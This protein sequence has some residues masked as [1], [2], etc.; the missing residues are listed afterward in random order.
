[1]WCA[2]VL[3]T[4]RPS[5]HPAPRAPPG[6]HAPHQATSTRLHA[7][8]IPTHHTTPMPPLSSTFFLPASSSNGQTRSG[9]RRSG[10]SSQ[11][12]AIRGGTAPPAGPRQP[13]PPRPALRG[14]LPR[15]RRRPPR[16]PP[17]RL[18]PPRPPLLRRPAPRPRRRAHR[19]LLRRSRTELCPWQADRGLPRL[20]R[21]GAP[22]APGRQRHGRGCPGLRLQ[23]V[24]LQG[25]AASRDPAQHAAKHLAFNAA[26]HHRRRRR[27]DPIWI[28]I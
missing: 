9:R 20:T 18:R 27:F 5:P 25:D 10:H 15:P 23:G 14:A 11:G 2:T 21:Q 16:P 6:H 19:Q 8:P 1:M 7:S 3:H 17:P 24:R 22:P 26:E 13:S 4:H 12:R 28:W